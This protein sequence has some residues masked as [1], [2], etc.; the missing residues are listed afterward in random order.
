MSLLFEPGRIGKMT[1]KNRFVR[2][3]AG[4]GWCTDNGE[5]TPEL[6]KFYSEL[7]DG[8]VGLITTGATYVLEK[9]KV[10]RFIGMYDDKVAEG[11]KKL[12]KAVHDY[13]SRIICQIFLPGRA[14]FFAEFG[15]SPVTLEMTGAPCR[16]ISEDEIYEFI[17]A[18]GQA[19]R[20]CKE[21]GFDG[22]QFHA[23]H[24]YLFHS[25]LSP[26][27]NLRTD[28]WGGSFENNMRF[29]TECYGACR[30]AAGNDYP[31]TIKVSVQDYLEGGLTFDMGKRYAA[32]MSE[33]GFDAIETSAGVNTDRPYYYMAKG[34]LP[35][36]GVIFGKDKEQT[37]Q[38]FRNIKNFEE[39]IKFE[40]AYFRPLAK[41]I[42]KTVKMP[43]ILPGG[44]RTV[45][46]M[47]DILKS[48]DADFIGL[49]R[50]LIR[51]PDFPDKVKKWGYEK[52]GCLNCNRCFT[53][54]KGPMEPNRCYQ[55]LFR[56]DRLQL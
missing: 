12:T 23:A 14:N 6:V 29:L 52:A 44:N 28:K 32:R 46:N 50:P 13:D 31:I 38:T 40:E 54:G 53:S 36:N 34:D 25:F 11:F 4:D 3:A 18:F 41:E 5:C 48:G 10:G 27:D 24:G 45:S 49:C 21:A 22:I 2:T 33:M 26:H 47:E 7:A 30:K 42:K 43:V 15:P 1:V 8:G 16:E 17:D 35:G 20:R 19:A 9:Y 55:L 51:E 56:P 37:R 39:D